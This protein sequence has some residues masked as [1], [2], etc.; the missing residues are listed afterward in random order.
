VPAELHELARAMPL[1]VATRAILEWLLDGPTIELLAERAAPA[2]Y[3]RDLAMAAVV[4]LMIQVSAGN[5]ATVFAAYRAFADPSEPGGP[6]ITVTYQA[7]YG[8]LGRMDPAVGTELVRYSAARLKEVMAGLDPAPQPLAGYRVKVVDGNSLAGTDHRLGPLRD[9]KAAALPGKSVVVFDV[10]TQLVSDLVLCEDAYR[11]ERVLVQDLLPGLGKRDLVLIDRNFC[12]TKVV[13]GAAS[14]EASFIVRH[15]AT[16]L[17][18]EPD[19]PEGLWLWRETTEAGMVW[20][21]EVIVT[22]PAT[23]ATLRLRQVQ[24]RLFTKTR[25]GEDT[26]TLLTNL[27]PGVSAA[28]VAE[29]YRGRWTVERHF[30]F[31]TEELHCE[32]AGLGKPRA[33]LF[34]FAMALVAGNALALVRGALRTA[35]GAEAE[36][37]TSGH[38]LADE[39]AADTR[40]LPKL[41]PPEKWLAFHGMA[42]GTLAGA[43]AAIAGHVRL[44]ALR[45]SPRGPKKQQVGPK[46]GTKV[47][48]HRSTARILEQSKISKTC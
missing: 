23:G 45:K 26:I 12:T 32:Q 5:R 36:E 24:L 6:Q 15:H 39:I 1:G 21:R 13:F 8:K 22:D 14:R 19:G 31:L 35:Q 37:G 29:L 16:S 9:H 33:A 7:L 46:I 40:T 3:V 48:K 47:H 34:A 38:Y 28:K 25:E 41:A 27:P 11:Q 2:Q 10:G 18:W 42:P 20:E 30:Q 44:W 43:L 17:S 4:R